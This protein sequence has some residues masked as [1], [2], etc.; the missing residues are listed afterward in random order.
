MRR[1]KGFGLRRF[2]VPISASG[3]SSSVCA[4][5]TERSCA[6]IPAALIL[7]HRLR[8]TALEQRLMSSTAVH[9]R[10]TSNGARR[11]PARHGQT[12]SAPRLGVRTHSGDRRDDQLSQRQAVSFGVPPARSRDGPHADENAR[13]K[14]RPWQIF[15]PAIFSRSE[16]S[17]FENASL[18]TGKGRCNSLT[19]SATIV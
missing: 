3:T 9:N 11:V 13:G 8:Q 19:V 18:A 14:L 5:S 6:G 7:Q 16:G 2:T 12:C 10:C 4:I 17:T 1:Y 15:L